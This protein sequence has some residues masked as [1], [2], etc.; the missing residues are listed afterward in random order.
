MVKD[1]LA[2]L[3]IISAQLW[4]HLHSDSGPIVQT[5]KLEISALFTLNNLESNHLVII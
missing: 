3:I 2:G 5:G 4:L 1:E